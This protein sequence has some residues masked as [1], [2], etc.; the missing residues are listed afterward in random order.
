MWSIGTPNQFSF[1]QKAKY[2]K[3]FLAYTVSFCLPKASFKPNNL[4]GDLENGSE[5]GTFNMSS[6]FSV[7][8]LC[9]QIMPSRRYL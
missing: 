7:I 8:I 9:C 3:V 5:S 6:E 2:V 1:F 4:D